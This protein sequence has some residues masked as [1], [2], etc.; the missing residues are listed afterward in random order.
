MAYD[1]SRSNFQE[2]AVR[3]ALRFY[4]NTWYPSEQ[5]I[6]WARHISCKFVPTELANMILDEA[7]YWLAFQTIDLQNY[8]RPANSKS[9]Q[10]MITPPIPSPNVLHFG[11]DG[12]G[13]NTPIIM[14]EVVFW[15][16]TRDYGY[17]EHHPD[18]P[19]NSA[20]LE[21]VTNPANG[22]DRWHLK[23]KD[24]WL[25]SKEFCR[26]TWKNGEESFNDADCKKYPG[27]RTGNGAGFVGSLK[28]GDRIAV[29]VHEQASF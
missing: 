9:L 2:G 3:I 23:S 10:Y 20:P 27:S 6:Y 21:L 29:I 11:E 22:G 12:N 19:V 13:D 26:I 1:S 17:Y 15:I 4:N 5:E 24:R 8:Y 7:R 14:K 18:R 16:G 28:I 25:E